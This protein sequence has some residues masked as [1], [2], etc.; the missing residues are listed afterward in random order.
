[1]VVEIE[2]EAEEVV[3]GVVVVVIETEAV[4]AVVIGEIRYF[5]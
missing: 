3:D 5:S 2:M 4:A 1:M